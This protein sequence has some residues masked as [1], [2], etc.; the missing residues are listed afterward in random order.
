VHV[1]EAMVN[2]NPLKTVGPQG[3]G[4]S[5]LSESRCNVSYRCRVCTLRADC[6]VSDIRVCYMIS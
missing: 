1:Q 6:Y 2:R 5:Q 3:K 4:S